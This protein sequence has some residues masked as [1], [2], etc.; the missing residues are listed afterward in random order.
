MI[1]TIYKGILANKPISSIHKELLNQTI[2]KNMLSYM[3]I[4]SRVASNKARQLKQKE[5]TNQ[6]MLSCFLADLIAKGGWNFESNKLI[7]KSIRDK[8]VE[9]KQ[10]ILQ[11][12]LNNTSNPKNVEKVNG[13][14]EETQTITEGQENKDVPTSEK[15]QYLDHNK[16]FWVCSSHDDSAKDHELYQG[17]IYY[18]ADYDK[19]DLRITQLINQKGYVSVQNIT[20]GPVWLIT[21]P[22]CRHYFVEYTYDDIISGHYHI[23]H[24]KIGMRKLGTKKI[25]GEGKSR[26]ERVAEAIAYYEDRLR[27]IRALRKIKDNYVLKAQEQKCLTLLKKWKG[28]L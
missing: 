15:P 2:N 27:T 25:S 23:P 16:V 13:N 11:D 19:R 17:K 8:Q 7:N 5:E 3:K 12:E 28:E 18:N 4:V 9:E 26:E 21:R 1:T 10:K 22:N 24:S 14:K 20:S 6:L